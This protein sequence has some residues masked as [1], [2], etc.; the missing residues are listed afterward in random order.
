MDWLVSILGITSIYLLGDKKKSGWVFKL[1][2][3]VI[4]I[5]LAISKELY[6]FIP[7]AA[8]AGILAIRNYIKWR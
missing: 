1:V 6:G 8:L 4:W 3:Q 5:Y 2:S 7:L